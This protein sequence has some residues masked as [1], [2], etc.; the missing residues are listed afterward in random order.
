VC[1]HR[2]PHRGDEHLFWDETNLQTMLKACH[3]GPKQRAEQA[4]L[5]QRC[6]WYR[7]GGG[8]VNPPRPTLAV[9]APLPFRDF[10]LAR[11]CF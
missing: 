4:S 11:H 6:V 9:P 5:N 3:D 10:F 1:D 7:W 2:K 8:W